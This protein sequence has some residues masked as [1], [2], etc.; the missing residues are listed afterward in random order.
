MTAAEIEAAAELK[1][2]LSPS[3]STSSET[4]IDVERNQGRSSPLLGKAYRPRLL[5]PSRQLPT[6]LLLIATGITLLVYLFQPVALDRLIPHQFTDESRPWYAASG[7]L[8]WTEEEAA[9]RNWTWGPFQPDRTLLV[10]LAL[11]SSVS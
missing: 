4:F 1:T 11:L 10:N 6:T 2:L 5:R 8:E 3:T 9:L 7:Q